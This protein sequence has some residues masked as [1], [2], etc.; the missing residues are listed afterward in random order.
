MRPLYALGETLGGGLKLTK[1]VISAFTE[2]EN[3]PGLLLD[4]RVNPGNSGGPM[5]DTCGNVIGLVSAKSLSNEKVDSYGMARPAQFLAAFLQ[6]HLPAYW[7]LPAK[8]RK[9]EWQG[10]D[11]LVSGSVVMVVKAPAAVQEMGQN[12]LSP[13]RKKWSPIRPG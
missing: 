9:L 1:G 2:D 3:V 7:P 12:S 4:L 8:T 10:V 5:C 11:R 6:Q 13:R